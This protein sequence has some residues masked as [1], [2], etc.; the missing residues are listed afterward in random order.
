[1]VHTKVD[2]DKFVKLLEDKKLKE[3]RTYIKKIE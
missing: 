3:A 1:M 2:I